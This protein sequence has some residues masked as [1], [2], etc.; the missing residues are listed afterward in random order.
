[1]SAPPKPPAPPAAGPD[2]PV[3][4][5]TAAYRWLARH[6]RE[7]PT[8]S[9]GVLCVALLLAGIGLQ[10]LWIKC[11]EFGDM[12]VAKLEPLYR[13][14]ME[15]RE[16]ELGRDHPET[17]LSVNGVALLLRLKG[18]HAGADLL[19]RR[20]LEANERM[21]GRAHTNLYS[22]I[23]ELSGL[24]DGVGGVGDLT[25]EEEK[26]RR[27]L[28]M[29][30]TALGPQHPL[31]LTSLN[32]LGACL[33]VKGDLAAAEPFTRKALELRE[34]T[35]GS[36]HPDTLVSVANLGMLH[37][38]RGDLAGAEPLAARAAREF[39]AQL[40]TEHRHTKFAQRLLTEIQRERAAKGLGK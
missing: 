28:H 11:G 15:Q 12:D 34:R 17:I 10:K 31:T 3:P 6:F 1:M 2:V 5:R 39:L 23:Q 22:D 7:H 20:L 9:V 27:E 29:R 24:L 33:R 21:V 37:R 4:R 14:T 16:R 25:A 40:G 13:Q 8:R 30:G 19:F 32:H 18:D 35:L 36:K 38:A 26:A